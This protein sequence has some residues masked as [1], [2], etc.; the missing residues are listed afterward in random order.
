MNPKRSDLVETRVIDGRRC[1][2]IAL[3]EGVEVNGIHV[4][5]EGDS[6]AA[7]EPAENAEWK[8]T[9]AG[10]QGYI[11]PGDALNE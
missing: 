9:D 7:Y 2:V 11:R 10:S 8:D 1:L 5:A 3:E 6:G 4:S